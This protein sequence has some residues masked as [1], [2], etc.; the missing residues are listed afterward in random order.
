MAVKI[1]PRAWNPDFTRFEADN[2]TLGKPQPDFVLGCPNFRACAPSVPKNQVSAAARPLT[3]AHDTPT[4]E[5][6][7]E[8]VE[9]AK[10]PEVKPELP[11]YRLL[12]LRFFRDLTEGERLRILTTL[13]AIPLD[14][15]DLLTQATERHLFDWLIGQGK[16][17]DIQQ[18]VEYYIQIKDGGNEG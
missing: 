13:D 16:L 11:G 9:N 3:A 12:L 8:V 2:S 4:V 6:V 1:H 14:A 5:I 7:A 10:E 18:L 17:E 15:E